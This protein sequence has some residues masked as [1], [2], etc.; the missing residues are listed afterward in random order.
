MS[1]YNN[2]VVMPTVCPSDIYEFRVKTKKIIEFLNSSSLL[3][4]H[5]REKKNGKIVKCTF[6]FSTLTEEDMVVAIRLVCGINVY[7]LTNRNILQ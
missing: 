7:S 1:E 6:S 2:R 4:F 3:T 5:S